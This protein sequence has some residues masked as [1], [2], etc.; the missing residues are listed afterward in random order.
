M[1]GDGASVGN[2][3][4]GYEFLEE[5]L[6][7]SLF[8]EQ[9]VYIYRT[10]SILEV[11]VT[12]LVTVLQVLHSTCELIPCVVVNFC[13]IELCDGYLLG[14]G[15]LTTAFTVLLVSYKPC[16]TLALSFRG[17]VAVVVNL[18]VNSDYVANVEFISSGQLLAILSCNLI[19][20]EQVAAVNCISN[21]EGRVAIGSV[22]LS[23]LGDIT[24][25]II[26]VL[27]EGSAQLFTLLDGS[28]HVIR[29]ILRTRSGRSN[30]TCWLLIG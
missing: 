1:D 15:S 22:C 10:G 19:A 27:R 20:C 8:R 13:G 4:L 26:L 21:G 29:I 23:G 2:T 3:V 28:S 30:R 11:E 17:L 7:T 12:I 9:T 6:S 5:F 16:S 14:I 24:L 25:D 18:T